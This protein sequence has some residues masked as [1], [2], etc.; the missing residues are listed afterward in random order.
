MTMVHILVWFL[1]PCSL[2]VTYCIYLEDQIDHLDPD[3]GNSKLCQNFG[4]HLQ[5]YKVSQPRR[6]QSV[7]VGGKDTLYDVFTKAYVEIFT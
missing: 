1:T 7:M 2:V 5:H 3:E 4:I 6:Q